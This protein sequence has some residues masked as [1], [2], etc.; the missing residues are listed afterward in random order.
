L[1][2]AV[3]VSWSERDKATVI[4]F[5]GGEKDAVLVEEN[6]DQIMGGK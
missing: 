4:A 2:K 1:K 6:P 5:I 3:S